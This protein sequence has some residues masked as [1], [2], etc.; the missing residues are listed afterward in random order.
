M[1][2][3]AIERGAMRRAT[4]KRVR[5]RT[6]VLNSNDETKEVVGMN[7]DTRLFDGC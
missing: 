7:K 4:R 3:K 2:R 5:T 1:G 6:P